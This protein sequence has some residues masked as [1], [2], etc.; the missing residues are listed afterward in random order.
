[1]SPTAEWSKIMGS[2]YVVPKAWASMRTSWNTNMDRQRA[3][4]FKYLQI[5]SGSLH[6]AKHIQTQG[7]SSRNSLDKSF[8]DINILHHHSALV[9]GNTLGWDTTPITC[10]ESHEVDST[11]PR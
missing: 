11:G 3:P 10:S 5:L 6:R 2:D 8:N 9:V 4:Y 7:F 1:M